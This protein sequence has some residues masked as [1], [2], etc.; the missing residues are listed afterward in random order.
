MLAGELDALGPSP[1]AEAIRR[2][3]GD[4]VMEALY[5]VE[6]KAMSPRLAR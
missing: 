3:L 1:W 4:A 6:R 2:E 5:A